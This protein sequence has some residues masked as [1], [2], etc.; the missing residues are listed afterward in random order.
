MCTVFFLKLNSSLA[1]SLVISPLR[2]TTPQNVPIWVN[3][4]KSIAGANENAYLWH[5]ASVPQEGRGEIF[6]LEPSIFIGSG[7]FVQGLQIKAGDVP[8]ELL[9]PYVLY[10]PTPHKFSCSVCNETNPSDCTICIPYANLSF[11]VKSGSQQSN[12]ALAGVIVKQ[13]SDAPFAG[14]G[15]GALYLDGYD[16][17]AVASIPAVPPHAITVA[18][19]VKN[20]RARPLQ[21]LF[22]IF[23]T[24]GRELEVH[25]TIDLQALRGNSGATPKAGV[26][27]ADGAWHHVAVSLH[28]ASGA[29]TLMVDA[30]VAAV[31]TLL[32]GVP[33]AEE[34]ELFIGQ[35]PVCGGIAARFARQRRREE[36]H[37][38][39]LRGYNVTQPDGRVY[40]VCAA[41]VPTRG[42]DV[43]YPEYLRDTFVWAL[44]NEEVLR[45]DDTRPTP[46]VERGAWR[47]AVGRVCTQ[48]AM[49]VTDAFACECVPGCMDPTFAFNGCELL[50]ATHVRSCRLRTAR[51][52]LRFCRI[53]TSRDAAARVM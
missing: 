49:A 48:G 18:M 30:K 12:T 14:G 11:F 46:A 53:H 28:I 42:C 22:S 45:R 6:S 5:M 4:S 50:H 26:S 40:R 25:N 33:L 34:A 32:P 37:A 31:A 10:V 43:F 44:D 41:D 21:T 15:G 23:S 52:C 2:L 39:F 35:R 7:K 24:R 9:Y 8:F 3:L 1:G 51:T 29:C 19:W 27:I 16:D 13:N 38:D 20:Q 47:C 36:R 17:F